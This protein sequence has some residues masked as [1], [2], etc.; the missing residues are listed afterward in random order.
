[1]PRL[2]NLTGN[3]AVDQA[4]IYS[5][6]VVL[7]REMDELRQKSTWE[8]RKPFQDSLKLK[9]EIEELWEQYQGR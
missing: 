5:R 4:A 7:R 8:N 9:A 2:T 6:I 3:R 1:M